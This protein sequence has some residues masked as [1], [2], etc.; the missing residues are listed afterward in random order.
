MTV[1][2]VK[3]FLSRIFKLPVAIMK[4]NYRDPGSDFPEKLG[5]DARSLESYGVRSGTLFVLVI[6]ASTWTL[7]FFRLIRLRCGSQGV[8]S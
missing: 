6:F 5:E 1:T 7:F 2:Q 3:L 4:L 8:K